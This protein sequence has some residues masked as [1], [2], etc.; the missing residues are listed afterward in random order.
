MRGRDCG[1]RGCQLRT[2]TPQRGIRKHKARLLRGL[3]GAQA[4]GREERKAKAF[5]GVSAHSTPPRVL[6]SVWG[7]F[8][9][10]ERPART[11][12]LLRPR[13]L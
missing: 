8:L 5:P 9:G 12:A 4:G 1:G 6:C 2:D 13:L 10:V 11:L 7:P 3:E